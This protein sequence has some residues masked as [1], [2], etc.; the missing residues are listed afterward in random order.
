MLWLCRTRVYQQSDLYMHTLLP[1]AYAMACHAPLYA[2]TQSNCSAAH[3]HSCTHAVLTLP[4]T[5]VMKK[6]GTFAGVSS[7]R[8]SPSHEPYT[9]TAT[10]SNRGAVRMSDFPTLDTVAQS[11]GATGEEPHKD[12]LADALMAL[13]IGTRIMWHGCV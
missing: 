7:N 13:K 11:T 2:L 10:S 6:Q 1:T 12:L 4:F 9:S 3:Q 5:T 8:F